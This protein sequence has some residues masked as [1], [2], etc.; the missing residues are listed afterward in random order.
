MPGAH[1]LKHFD[2]QIFISTIQ[3]YTR[4][5]HLYYLNTAPGSDIRLY[6]H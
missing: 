4:S 2:N 5:G 3:F 1:L 6:I